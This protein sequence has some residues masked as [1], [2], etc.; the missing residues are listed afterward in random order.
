MPVGGV[1]QPAPTAITANFGG[2]FRRFRPF[3]LI[4]IKMAVVPG[5]IPI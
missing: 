1:I 2:D 3:R 5:R 4:F